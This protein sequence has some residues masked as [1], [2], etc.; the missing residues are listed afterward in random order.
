MNEIMDWEVDGIVD[1]AEL[2]NFLDRIN[3]DAPLDQGDAKLML[4][5]YRAQLAACAAGPWR[6]DVENAPKDGSEII[7]WFVRLPNYH[8]MI[9]VRWC[10]DFEAWSHI[11]LG[12]ARQNSTLI[13]FA[14]PNPPQVMS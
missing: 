3:N 8:D 1:E 2:E 7:G 5:Y 13:A 4:S 9:L 10:N 14:V 11:G 6:T 12:F